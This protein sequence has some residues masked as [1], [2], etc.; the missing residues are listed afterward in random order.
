MRLWRGIKWLTL[1]NWHTMV[2]YGSGWSVFP[3]IPPLSPNLY[4]SPLLFLWLP[5]LSVAFQLPDNLHPQKYYFSQGRV[6]VI[7]YQKVPLKWADGMFFYI[8]RENKKKIILYTLNAQEP[9]FTQMIKEAR[10]KGRN[11]H[12]LLVYYFL[13]RWPTSCF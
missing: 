9:I 5:C 1:C 12:I 11:Y 13:I 4:L 8:S 7:I 3:V 10:E 2:H 6:G